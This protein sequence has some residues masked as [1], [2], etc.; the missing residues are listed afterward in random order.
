MPQSITPSATSADCRSLKLEFL[1]ITAWR[2]IE[3][4]EGNAK[5]H[6]H[7]SRNLRTS[8]ATCT[9]GAALASAAAA[10][11]QEVAPWLNLAA[12]FLS[13]NAGL[14]AGYESL[15]NLTELWPHEKAISNALR[16]LARDVAFARCCEADTSIS[17]TKFHSR[18]QAIM[19]GSGERWSRLAQPGAPSTNS[20]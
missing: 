13:T 2:L 1:Q 3:E 16:D 11:F 17:P 18:L 19:A 9:A 12:V 7:L 5:K 6:R 15:H 4:F 10:T 20:T 14:L 8:E